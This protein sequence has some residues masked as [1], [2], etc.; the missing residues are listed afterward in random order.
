MVISVMLRQDIYDTLQCFGNLNEVTDRIL[1][2]CMQGEIDLE[3]APTITD[4]KSNRK[5]YFVDVTNEEYLEY[6]KIRGER[7]QKLS[8][9]RILHQF[10][11]EE[12]Y[13][14]LG[15]EQCHNLKD[16]KVYDYNLQLSRVIDGIDKLSILSSENEVNVLTDITKLLLSIKRG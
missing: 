4:P 9:S 10:V 13:Y 1:T 14:D 3:S 8:L 16:I 7:S 12:M 2:L 5:Q 15:W 11:D 6:R